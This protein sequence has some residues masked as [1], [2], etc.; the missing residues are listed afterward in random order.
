MSAGISSGGELHAIAP[1][2]AS[3]ISVTN[4]AI[5][6]RRLILTMASAPALTNR[7]MWGAVFKLRDYKRRNKAMDPRTVP[8]TRITFMSRCTRSFSISS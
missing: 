6:S 3:T 7:L 8:Q 2:I 5:W 1:A 4:D